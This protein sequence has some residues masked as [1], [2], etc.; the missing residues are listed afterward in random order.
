MSSSPIDRFVGACAVICASL[1]VVALV[2]C[3]DSK[4]AASVATV[5]R[6]APASGD[7]EKITKGAYLAKVGNCAGCHTVPGGPAMAGGRRLDT[8]YG[9]VFTSNLTPDDAT[10]LG[11]WSADDFHRAMHE[12]LSPDGRRLVPAF[13]Y[14]SYTHVSREDNDALFAYLRSLP[15][16]KLARR[17]HELRFPFG[18]PVAM[19]VWQWFNFTPAAE[20]QR[21]PA[22]GITRGAYLVTGLGHCGECHAPRNRWS[23]P[24]SRLEG[25]AMP[26]DGW[27]APSLHPGPGASDEPAQTVALLRDGINARGVASGPMAKVVLD[28]TQHWLPADLQWA[29]SYLSNLPPAPAPSQAPE[30]DPTLRATGARLYTDRCA[31]CHGADGQGVRGVYPP[32]AGNPTVVQPSVLTLIRVLDHGGFAAATAG[33]PKPYGMP[34]AML[35]NEEMAAVLTYV[36]QSW[37]QRAHAVSTLDVL[38]SR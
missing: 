30:A 19:A 1:C 3:D 22:E 26:G 8:P 7:P 37:S 17:A 15:P 11:R 5:E 18:T 28:S 32:L 16:V 35:S 34:P 24:G 6:P 4:R 36:R 2:G 29:A 31:D 33:N 12:G 9:A 14:T 27:F 25:G 10:G 38:R 21:S 13:P 23:A 20:L